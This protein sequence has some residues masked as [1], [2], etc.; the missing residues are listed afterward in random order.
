MIRTKYKDGLAE[1]KL[2]GY[3]LQDHCIDLFYQ[4]EILI[5]G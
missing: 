1:G 3:C 4:G 2:K 5:P